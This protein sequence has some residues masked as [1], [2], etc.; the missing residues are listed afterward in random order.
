MY[1][2][3]IISENPLD[4]VKLLMN[5]DL[6][7][8]KTENVMRIFEQDV[9]NNQFISN[10]EKGFEEYQ[11]KGFVYMKTVDGKVLEVPKGTVFLEKIENDAERLEYIDNLL[12]V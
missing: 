4:R 11:N 10:P 9:N 1:K 12:N 3:L 8:T 6:S 7:A 5:Y 2:N